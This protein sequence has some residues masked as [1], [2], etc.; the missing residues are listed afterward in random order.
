MVLMFCSSRV[1]TVQHLGQRLLCP[2][3]Q[4]DGQLPVKLPVDTA[5][6]AA[7]HNWGSCLASEMKTTLFDSHL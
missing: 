3:P 7:Q 6:V 1:D 2:L 5:L 4:L